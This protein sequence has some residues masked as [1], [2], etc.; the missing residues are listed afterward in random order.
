MNHVWQRF[1]KKYLPTLI[2]RR[3]Q[4]DNNQFPLKVKDFLWV[5]KSL[6]PRGFWPLGNV[7][8]TSTGRDGEVWVAKVETVYGSFAHPVASF[9]RH[10]L[11]S[12][13][14]QCFA[15]AFVNMSYI[16]SPFDVITITVI[17]I[18][19]HA[20]WRY[21]I[22]QESRWSS[23][24]T[25]FREHVSNNLGISRK[26]VKTRNLPKS[27]LPPENDRVTL[28]RKTSH[29]K[30]QP[31]QSNQ[32]SLEYIFHYINNKAWKNEVFYNRQ[33]VSN[34]AMQKRVALNIFQR[35]KKSEFF[36]QFFFAMLLWNRKDELV[37]LVT[38]Y[39]DGIKQFNLEI[40]KFNSILPVSFVPIIW[41]QFK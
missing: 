15:P 19:Q 27:K 22:R 37:T 26:K 1:M 6:T 14:R 13:F 10:F 5:L 39:N 32:T 3:K 16:H 34:Y 33:F 17:L 23:T 2:K 21:R 25:S 8:E 29:K 7:V 36:S 24:L 38:L 18:F 40:W 12:F 4:T 28:S 9:A 35:P 11:R 31:K 20:G 41:H 30:S